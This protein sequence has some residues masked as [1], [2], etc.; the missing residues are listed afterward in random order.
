MQKIN[1]AFKTES[2][3]RAIIAII[4]IIT[5]T[6]SADF[7]WGFVIGA[8]I[9]KDNINLK[10]KEG[11]TLL[12]L[13]VGVMLIAIYFLLSTEAIFGYLASTVLYFIIRGIL[14]SLNK[15]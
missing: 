11:W 2:I 5:F 15:K 7:G 1:N 6:I 8:L 9:S 4:G 10:T 13:I 12:A 14:T 3:I